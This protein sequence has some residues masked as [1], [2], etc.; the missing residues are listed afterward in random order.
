MVALSVVIIAGNEER[1]IGRCLH[2]VKAIADEI[3]VV[4]S[5]SADRTQEICRSYGVRLIQ[6]AWPG[7]V[8]QKNYALSHA[9]N[10]W[11]LSLDADEA[12]S[13]ELKQSILSVLDNPIADA[14]SMNR[15]TNYCGQWIKH[16]GWYPDRKIRLFNRHNVKWGGMNPHDRIIMP[17]AAK[18][19]HING[20][21]L[22]YSYYTLSDHIQ[23]I[24]HFSDVAAQALYEKGVRSNLLK[25]ILKPYVRFIKSYFLKGGFRDGY[26]GYLIARNSAFASFARYSKLRELQRN[27]SK[28]CR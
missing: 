19:L 1:N 17:P 20:D 25:L 28:C 22:H 24:D 2:S 16:G 6:N 7:Y 12:L 21:I 4:D 11:V 15:L 14:Y 10:Q 5:I 27:K 3:V 23:Q 18:V 26:Y 8:E 9:T 13:S